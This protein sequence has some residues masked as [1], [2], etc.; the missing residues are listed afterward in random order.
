M[1]L[2]P[3]LSS[4][5]LVCAAITAGPGALQAADGS[6][7]LCGNLSAKAADVVLHCRRALEGD[8]SRGDAEAARLNLGDALIATGRP[9]LALDAYNEAEREGS[10][11]VELY[12][13]RA[14]ALEAMDRRAEAAADWRRAVE[15]APRSFDARLGLGAFHLRG[16]AYGDA[17]AA[18]DAALSIDG[19]DAD[20]RYNRGLTLLALDRKAEAEADFSRLL[21][22]DPA[23]AGAWH[24]RAR[25]RVGRDDRAA[26]ADFDEAIRLSP[27]WTA[28]WYLSGR[29]LDDNGRV[30]DANFRFRRAFELGANT[31]W[32]L[33]RI[34]SLGG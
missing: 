5:F 9:S 11:R 26:L 21:R 34:Q 22:D 12:I 30:E 20:A 25:A 17:L 18:F 31:P 3:F 1:K 13:G 32:L 33:N 6:L 2:A 23:D 8:L 4:A 16:G 19:D 27:E 28:P 24:H 15:R 7:A 14:S 10:R 29:L